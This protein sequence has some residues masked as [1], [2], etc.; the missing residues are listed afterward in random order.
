MEKGFL[1]IQA[2]HKE[3]ESWIQMWICLKNKWIKKK[4]I[5]EL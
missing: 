5:S 3:T 4:R 2:G 1:P